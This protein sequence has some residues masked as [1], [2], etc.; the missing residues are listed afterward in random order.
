MN[1]IFTSVTTLCALATI[2][3]GAVVIP[4]EGRFSWNYNLLGSGGGSGAQDQF[5]IQFGDDRLAAG[6]SLLMTV[7]PNGQSVPSWTRTINGFGAG[8]N[9]FLYF[10]E[11][12][13]Y[14]PT[15]IGTLN[16]E[17]LSGTVNLERITII[18]NTPVDNTTATI[19]PNFTLIPEPGTTSL[20]FC[21]CFLLAFRHR[22]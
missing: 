10:G 19:S 1:A 17:I 22:S 2:V 6:E 7:I 15:R 5:A 11:I 4:E 8:L 18:L 21:G 12:D 13:A 9:G 20:F 14:F 3:C 16:F